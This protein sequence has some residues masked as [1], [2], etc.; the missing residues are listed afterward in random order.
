MM[1]DVEFERHRAELAERKKFIASL[2]RGLAKRE[3]PP[4]PQTLSVAPMDTFDSE[5]HEANL[6]RARAMLE[7][8]EAQ[9]KAAETEAA[10]KAEHFQSWRKNSALAQFITAR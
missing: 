6:R 1:T 5:A 4:S 3:D 9:R 10:E 7:I 8:E 2:P